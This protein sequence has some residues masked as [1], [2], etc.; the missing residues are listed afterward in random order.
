MRDIML[1]AIATVLVAGASLVVFQVADPV[2]RTQNK[3]EGLADHERGQAEVLDT[4]TN[5]LKG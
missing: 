4:W 3:T 1:A 2:T 5:R